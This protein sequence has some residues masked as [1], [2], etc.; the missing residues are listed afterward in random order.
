MASSEVDHVCGKDTIYILIKAGVKPL[1]CGL[2]QEVRIPQ[3]H[4]G[5][6]RP[7]DDMLVRSDVHIGVLTYR[8][9][10]SQGLH[11]LGAAY[12]TA[13]LEDVDSLLLN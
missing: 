3:V 10:C 4:L 1:N 9:T 5:D 7:H 6:E 8:N 2:G 13:D 11:Q 12:P